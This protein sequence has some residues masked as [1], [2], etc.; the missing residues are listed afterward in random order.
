M[1]AIL[2]QSCSRQAAK[3]GHAATLVTLLEMVP[4][5]DL[6]KPFGSGDA[7][8]PLAA[9]ADG[10]SIECVRALVRRRNAQRLKPGKTKP[11]GLRTTYRTQ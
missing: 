4:P 9:A 7:T 10:G 6:A 2:F 11:P 8:T 1:A 5:G 3:A